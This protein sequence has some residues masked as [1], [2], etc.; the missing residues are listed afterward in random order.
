LVYSY[1][2]LASSLN[3]GPVILYTCSNTFN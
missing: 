2:S 3:T 1:I